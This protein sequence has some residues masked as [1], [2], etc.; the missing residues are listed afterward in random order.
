[1]RSRVRGWRRRPSPLRRR[2]DVVEAWTLLAVAVTL[3]VVAPLVG[4][5]AAWW[6]HDDARATVKER[7]DG[8]RQVRAEVVGRT[9]NAVP[10][11]YGGRR[12]S[13]NVT[14]R[15]TDPANGPRT[16][17]A[18]VPAGTRPGET[19]DVWLDSRGRGVAPPPDDTAVWQ[20]TVTIGVCV[21]VGTGALI[22][23]GHTVVRHTAMSRRMAE[24]EA[25][26]A[27]TEPEWTGRRA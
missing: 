7:R 27:H 22:L 12:P 14:V 16:A 15:W 23:L 9:S 19:V 1:M 20:H 25:E 26:W 10:M 3:V 18:H 11:A 8:R 17:T 4:V 6:A 13:A 5:F 21:T 24:W 2:S